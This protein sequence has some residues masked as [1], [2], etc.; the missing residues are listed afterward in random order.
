MRVIKK[1]TINE[2][3]DKYT[4]SKESFGK[5]YLTVKSRKFL[6]FTD[7]KETFAGVDYVGNDLYVFNIKGNKYRLIVRIFF[8]AQVVYIRFIGTHAQYDEVD[9]STF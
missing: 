6:N 3:V 1:S 2:F 5:W 8:E 9:L 4:D 7:L